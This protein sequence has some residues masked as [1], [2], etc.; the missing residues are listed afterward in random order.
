MEFTIN[1]GSILKVA[2]VAAIG[3][4]A[5]KSYK[6]SKEATSKLKEEKK[7]AL[8]DGNLEKEVVA[9]TLRNEALSTESRAFMYDVCSKKF[10]DVRSAWTMDGFNKKLLQLEAMLFQLDPQ[11]GS[12]D[13]IEAYAIYYK[14]K[15]DEIKHEKEVRRQQDY[16][17]R[18]IRQ[19]GELIKPPKQDVNVTV[20]TKEVSNES[21]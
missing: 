19:F 14:Q 3:Y 9:K 16:N 8:D 4:F 12:K 2:A 10:N 15:E 7:K 18:Q 6:S 21:E 13:S 17:L 11:F 5:Y 20:N 1:L